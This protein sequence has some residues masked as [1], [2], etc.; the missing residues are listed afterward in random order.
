MPIHAEDETDRFTAYVLARY[1]R[2]LLALWRADERL[3]QE[4]RALA[5][6]EL[7]ELLRELRE[8]ER[9]GTG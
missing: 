6:D 8:E 3:R 9:R 1:A 7:R 2:A 5:R 4:V